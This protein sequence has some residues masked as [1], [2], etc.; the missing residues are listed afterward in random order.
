MKLLALFISA[1]GLKLSIEW[2]T[3]WKRWRNSTLVFLVGCGRDEQYFELRG[4]G[5]KESLTARIKEHVKDQLPQ[6]LPKEVSNFAPSVIEALIKESHDKVTLAKVSSQP[7]ST[8][9]AASTL[10]E[11]ELKKILITKIEKSESYLAAPEHRDCY[12][13][14]I[15]SYDLNKSLFSTYGKVYSLMCI[16]EAKPQRQKTKMRPFAGSDRGFIR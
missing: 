10:T 14:L 13:G 4:E 2:G 1:V 8:Y 9:E 5:L 6:I 7:H 3:Q 16:L 11:F 15:K 12:N